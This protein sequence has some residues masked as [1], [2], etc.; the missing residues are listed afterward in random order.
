MPKTKKYNKKNKKILD[1]ILEYFEMAIYGFLLF[2][3]LIYIG[4]YG[5]S[6]LILKGG[7]KHEIIFNIGI[8]VVLVSFCV[9]N[10][11]ESFK[12]KTLEK[13]KK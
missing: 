13:E 7:T 12:K 4:K 10:L 1:Y 6:D 5:L 9:D 8:W 11:F 3:F 2:F